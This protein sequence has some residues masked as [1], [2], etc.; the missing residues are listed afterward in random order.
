MLHLSL[1]LVVATANTLLCCVLLSMLMFQG[2]G[3]ETLVPV[4]VKRYN[5]RLLNSTLA[6][7]LEAPFSFFLPVGA[8]TIVTDTPDSEAVCVQ[9]GAAFKR[10]VEG[11]KSLQVCL[12]AVGDGYAGRG[13]EG[14][15]QL[16]QNR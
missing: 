4:A 9:D 7:K 1:T 5:E 14:G 13:G 10:A 15:R 2:A 3:P 11:N 16:G 8:P 12:S 6:D